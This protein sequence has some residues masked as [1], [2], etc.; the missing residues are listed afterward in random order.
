MRARN[1]RRYEQIDIQT[2]LEPRDNTPSK[3]IENIKMS[4]M[5][6]MRKDYK[7]DEDIFD[8][9]MKTPEAVIDFDRTWNGKYEYVRCGNCNG[10]MLGHREEKCR[11]K[12][13]VYDEAIVKRYEN[14]MRSCVQMRT[15]LIQYINKKKKEEMDYK[16]DRE[17]ELSKELPAKTSLMI[18]RTEIPKWIGQEFDVWKKEL[19]KWNENDKSSDETKYCN[20]MESLKKNDQIKDYVIT[21]LAEKTENDR[22][23]TAIL[24]VMA[25]KYEKTMSERCLSLMAEIVNFKADGGIEKITDKFGRMMAEVKKIDL[26][27]NLDY[28]MTL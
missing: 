6:A 28:A 9:L 11:H 14:N 26:A 4:V 2:L 5:E 24:K 12:E 21:T 18:G 13:G 19:E 15:I 25:E 8:E 27:A 22:K 3:K 17:L 20:V 23:V 1:F 10:P 7:S 16:Q